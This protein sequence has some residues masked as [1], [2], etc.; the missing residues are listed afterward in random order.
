MI[1]FFI[2]WCWYLHSAFFLID[3][4]GNITWFS[5]F[6]LFYV[7]RHKCVLLLLKWHPFSTFLKILFAFIF[8]DF[9]DRNFNLQFCFL[10]SIFTSSLIQGLFRNALLNFPIVMDF[11]VS[12]LLVISDL[13]PLQPEN[14][15]WMLLIF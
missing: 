9:W 4:K 1:L 2:Q 11:L 14:I 10:T 3:L 12:F 5:W 13:I 15:L 6:S 8:L 7:S